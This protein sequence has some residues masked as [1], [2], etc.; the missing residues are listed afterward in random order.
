VRISP[1]AAAMDAERKKKK[2][3]TFGRPQVDR[4]LQQELLLPPLPTL[5]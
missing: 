4:D 1:S 3:L 2:L 5:K